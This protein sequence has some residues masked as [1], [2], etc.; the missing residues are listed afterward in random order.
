MVP[1]LPGWTCLSQAPAVVQP[2]PGR[3]SLI[4]SNALPVLVKTKLCLT[5]SPDSTFPKSKVFVVNSILGPEG[6]GL[7]A[8]GAALVCA[9]VETRLPITARALNSN[10]R[11]RFTLGKRGS[12]EEPGSITRFWFFAVSDGQRVRWLRPITHQP[13]Q[14]VDLSGRRSKRPTA[15]G[16]SADPRKEC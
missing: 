2:Q 11:F 4:S 14:V 7:V 8:F 10:T 5:G 9:R 3:T 6:G 15:R 12:L 13:A 16:I 1:D